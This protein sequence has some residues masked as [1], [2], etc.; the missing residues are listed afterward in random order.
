MILWQG[1]KWHLALQNGQVSHTEIKIRTN[2]MIRK[3]SCTGKCN[4]VKKAVSGNMAYL[5]NYK[6]YEKLNCKGIAL[7]RNQK[8]HYWYLLILLSPYN[9]RLLLC[10]SL[11]EMSLGISNFLEEISSLSYF[12][13]FLYFYALI[14]E[15]VFLIS[16]FYS[17]KLFIQMCI[18]FLF[19][20]SLLFM[21]RL[22]IRPPQTTILPFF[23]SF[24]W[25]KR[26]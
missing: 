2:H 15:E 17:L 26:S 11:H 3:E 5:L 1:S 16:P 22:F 13:V 18:S 14:T 12:I 24:S 10:P 8:G 9:F 6:W 21:L 20:L 19:C 23:I 4:S 7:L 25:G